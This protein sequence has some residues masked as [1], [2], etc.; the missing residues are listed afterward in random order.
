[1]Q[2]PSEE[3]SIKF[4]DPTLNAYQP[5]PQKPETNSDP[6]QVIS[7][8]K[9][10]N[11]LVWAL[12]LLVVLIFGGA[13]GVYLSRQQADIRQQAH[14][15]ESRGVDCGVE[16]SEGFNEDGIYWYKIVPKAGQTP[17]VHANAYVCSGQQ[18]DDGTVHC[19]GTSEYQGVNRLVETP[20]RP[21]DARRGALQEAVE[22]TFIVPCGG[23][24]QID[25]WLAQLIDSEECT[26]EGGSLL[27]NCFSYDVCSQYLHIFAPVCSITP[28]PTIP[29]T[30]PTPPQTPTP[31]LPVSTPTTTPSISPTPTPT[32]GPTSTPVPPTATPT[33]IEQLTLNCD[34]VCSSNADCANTNHICF[35]ASDGANRCRLESNPTDQNCQ[36]A[37]VAQQ[38]Q[39]QPQLPS[40]LPATGP[41][42]WM[43][44]L[45]A[46]LAAV[47]VGAALLL[48]L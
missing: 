35:T 32:G 7:K 26:A 11:G 22:G 12:V 1:M 13:V 47:G 28:T 18:N 19:D 31:T 30:T 43:T 21:V 46:G 3:S 14:V 20:R 36:P 23:E 16:V 33:L 38:P 42:E 37:Q 10:P 45:Q 48:L 34:D 29:M 40:E 44:W 27:E 25:F 4:P 17:L 6:A 9:T 39:T 41:A 8:K 15:E 5:V 2:N 24:V